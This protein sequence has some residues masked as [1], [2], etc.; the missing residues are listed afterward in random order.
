M[1]ERGV[2]YDEKKHGVRGKGRDLYFG[3]GESDRSE[4]TKVN[5]T[6]VSWK[7]SIR[8]RRAVKRVELQIRKRPKTKR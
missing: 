7:G 2:G 4:Q 6:V 1:P 5:Q 3:Q 8:A